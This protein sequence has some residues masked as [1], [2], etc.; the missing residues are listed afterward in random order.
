MVAPCS[1]STPRPTKPR[2]LVGA[3]GSSLGSVSSRANPRKINDPKVGVAYY[4]YRYLDPNTGRWES[5]DP[6]EERGGV[7]LYGFVGNSALSRFDHLGLVYPSEKKW[8]RENPICCFAARNSD[9]D[10]RNEI[11]NRYHSLLENSVINAVQHCAWMCYI[12]S[13][14]CCSEKDARG[15]GN[16][17]EETPYLNPE[18]DKAMDLYNNGLGLTINGRGLEDCVNKCEAR[19]R[20]HILYWFAPLQEGV[21]F[22]GLPRDFPS[23]QLNTD[24]M[25]VGKRNGFG[26]A[27]P[28][29]LHTSN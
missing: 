21:V 12:K 15:L 3:R 22:L 2:P 18:H 10:V 11:W 6:I 26:S 25:V 20:D 4:G 1:L 7:N 19:A 24:G 28:P 23:F 17:H 8:C 29:I 9:T 13:L 27:T 14:S 16:A 5:R